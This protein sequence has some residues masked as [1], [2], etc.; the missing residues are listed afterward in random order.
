LLLTFVVSDEIS[1][2]FSLTAVCRLLTCCFSCV[3][4]S[5]TRLADSLASSA[6]C[7]A[8]LALVCASLAFVVATVADCCALFAFCVAVF[9]DCKAL[10]AFSVAVY[11]TALEGISELESMD[12]ELIHTIYE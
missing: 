9:A 10:S 5:P 4:S 2:V 3:T 8:L 7:F 11:P 12:F 1:D 6:Y